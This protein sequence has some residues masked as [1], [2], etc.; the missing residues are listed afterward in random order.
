MKTDAKSHLRYLDAVIWQERMRTGWL[1]P[2]G[3]AFLR[4]WASYSHKEKEAYSWD[5]NFSYK[6]TEADVYRAYTQVACLPLLTG[7]PMYIA[8]EVQPLILAGAR[9]M[10]LSWSLEPSLVFSNTGFAWFEHPVVVEH[11]NI[12]LSAVGWTPIWHTGVAPIT[13][14]NDVALESEDGL[15]I[16]F[17]GHPKAPEMLP[18][19]ITIMPLTV[20]KTLEEHFDREFSTV[21]EKAATQDKVC[22]FAALLTFLHQRLL[23]REERQVPRQWRRRNRRDSWARDGVTIIKLRLVERLKGTGALVPVEWTCRWLVSGHWRQQWYASTRRHRPVWITPY[24]KGPED[25]PLKEPRGLLFA[26]VR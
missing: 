3:R 26:V 8:A 13:G 1:S 24:I 2:S 7:Q 14:A 23:I 11:G 10:P 9:Q 18:M 25:K 19:P 20:S 12:P 16:V 17:Y 21:F 22:L 15:I 4:D 6:P 5:K